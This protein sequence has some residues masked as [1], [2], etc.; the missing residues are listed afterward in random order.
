MAKLL[1]VNNNIV[2]DCKSGSLLVIT[3]SVHDL[4]T[5]S[6]SQLLTVAWA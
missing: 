6:S 3:V 2:G 4:A 5:K 1:L